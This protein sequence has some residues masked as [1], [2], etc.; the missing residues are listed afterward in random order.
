M[1]NNSYP[2][3]DENPNPEAGEII[4]QLG[5]VISCIEAEQAL[6]GGLLIDPSPVHDVLEIL[7][8]ADFYR[9]AHRK[10]F[11]AITALVDSG[12][13]VDVISVAERW[14]ATGENADLAYLTE[15][16]GAVAGSSNAT[17]Y[18]R[19]VYDRAVKRQVLAAAAEVNRYVIATPSASAAEVAEFAQTALTDLNDRSERSTRAATAPQVLRDYVADLDARFRAGNAI[20]GLPSG[21]ANVDSI[22]NGWKNGHLIVI[23]ARPSMGKTTYAMQLASFLALNQKRN[24]LI[25]TLEMSRTELME[26]WLAMVGRIDLE[27]L[28]KPA[29]VTDEGFWPAVENAARQVKDAPLSFVECPGIH[30]RQLKS[31]ARKAHRRERL[32]FLLADHMHLMAADGQSRERQLSDISSGLKTLAIELGIPVFALAQLNRKVESRSADERAPRLSDLR[33]SGS[34]EQ[35]ADLIQLLYRADYYSDNPNP[36]NDGLVQVETAKNRNGRTGVCTFLNRYHQS[37]LDEAPEGVRIQSALLSR[38]IKANS[39]QRFDDL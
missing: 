9:P 23:A 3:P 7:S 12:S 8:D 16:A 37:R 19:M 5:A 11:S 14:Q 24:G 17:A 18:A 13:D 28:Q 26:K 22:V 1:L 2:Y 4:D 21:F 33:D 10:I 6:L 38:K 36:A 35:D 32:D 20:Q 27:K 34:I 25:F 31:Y 29:S 15:L 30:I 39:Y